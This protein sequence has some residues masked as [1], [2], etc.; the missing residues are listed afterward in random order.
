M[1]RIKCNVCKREVYYEMNRQFCSDRC[2]QVSFI[3][4]LSQADLNNQYRDGLSRLAQEG[5]A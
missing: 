4:S 3:R 5:R 1:K 2:R